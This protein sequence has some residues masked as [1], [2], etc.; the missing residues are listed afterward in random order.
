[1]HKI[2]PYVR[3]IIIN[4]EKSD[5]WKIQLIAINF[6]SSK[7]VDEEHAMHLKSDNIEF[8]YMIV[9]MKLLMNF[10]SHFFQGT[11]LV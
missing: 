8:C 6:I 11:K 10:S 5:T 2:K 1:M 4:L 3:D 7:N 9:Q